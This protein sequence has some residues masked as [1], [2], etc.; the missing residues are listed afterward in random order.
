MIPTSVPAIGDR[1][2]LTRKALGY[3]QQ[4]MGHLIGASSHSTWNN[5]EMGKRRISIEHALQL[6]SA[7]GA[8]L[9]WIY[10]G[11]IASLPADLAAKIQAVM[12][13][14]EDRPE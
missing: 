5:Y 4:F 13:Q 9:D 3:T 8:T 11:N 12:V 7:T 14:E 2:K 6:C 10:R 1:L